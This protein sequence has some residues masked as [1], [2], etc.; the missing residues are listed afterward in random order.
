[1]NK[2]KPG[3]RMKLE[4]QKEMDKKNKDILDLEEEQQQ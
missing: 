3:W 4:N 1:M 2:R